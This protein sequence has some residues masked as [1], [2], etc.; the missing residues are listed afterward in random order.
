MPFCS[1]LR[2]GPQGGRYSPH[3]EGAASSC[4]NWRGTPEGNGVDHLSPRFGTPSDWR[5]FFFQ[6]SRSASLGATF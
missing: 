6:P 1:D 4:T 2:R 5:S 3:F